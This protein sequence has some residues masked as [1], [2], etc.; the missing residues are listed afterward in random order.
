MS[1]G[2]LPVVLDR[3]QKAEMRIEVA[4]AELHFF[5]PSAGKGRRLALSGETFAVIAAG[6]IFTAT[7]KESNCIQSVRNLAQSTILSG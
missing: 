5:A 6:C 1:C 7:P 2:W 3:A 4:G